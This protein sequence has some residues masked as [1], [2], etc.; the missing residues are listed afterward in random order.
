MRGL[1]VL[2][3][4]SRNVGV[5]VI[6]TSRKSIR[7]DNNTGDEAGGWSQY[8][9]GRCWVKSSASG[10]ASRRAG[11]CATSSEIACSRLSRHDLPSM[12]RMMGRLSTDLSSVALCGNQNRSGLV[13]RERS[14]VDI[15]NLGELASHRLRSLGVG[16]LCLNLGCVLG[17]GRGDGFVGGLQGGR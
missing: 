1:Y 15:S 8:S 14:D 9:T 17:G 2:N 3:Y 16:V 6:P 11:F 12:C 7:A 13:R 10:S 5:L 4:V